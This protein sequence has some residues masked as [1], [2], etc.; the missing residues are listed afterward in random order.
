MARVLVAYASKKG[1][2]AEIAQAV[3]KELQAAGHTAD[4]LLAGTVAS[5]AGYDA[6]VI[7]G[8]M[9][10]GTL[11]GDVQKFSKRHHDAL[12]KLPV[13]GFVVCL[14]AATNDKEGM[15]CATKELHASLVPLSLVA[16]T[17]FAGRLDPA[18][19]SWFQNWIIKKVKSPV[20]DFRDGETIRAWA[21]ELSGKMNIS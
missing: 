13:A 2:T 10:M 7:G 1:S 11:I 5:L 21:R 18:K 17:V 14:A 8:P 20:G 6:V 9:Y 16:E 15:A 19:L 3:G 12:L 4:V